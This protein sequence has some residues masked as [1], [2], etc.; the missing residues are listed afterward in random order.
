PYRRDDRLPG[1]DDRAAPGGSARLWRCGDRRAIAFRATTKTAKP[2]GGETPM[3]REHPFS[4][5]RLLKGAGM[6]GATALALTN[7]LGIGP[8]F[9][10]VNPARAQGLAP[11]MIG[12][13]TGFPGAERFQYSANDSEG[14]V[15]EGLKKL[16]ADG[17]APDQ[18]TVLIVAS[19]LPQFIKPLPV[20]GESV[21]DTWEREIGIKLNF[22][23]IEASEIWKKVLQD[24]TTGSGSFDIYCHS[25]NN[26]GDLVTAG[27]AANLDE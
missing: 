17:K 6:A 8:R 15:I 24:V 5:R 25:W 22:V 4:R 3:T 19:C 20:G 27:G 9:L 12:G 14:H 1:I 7:P 21:K 23:G 16:K 13:P 2:T 10:R 26:V 11:G 18:L